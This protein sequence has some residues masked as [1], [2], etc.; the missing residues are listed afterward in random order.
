[1]EITVSTRKVWFSPS[2]GRHF[3]TSRAA[4]RAEA[5]AK[6]IDRYPPE[7]PDYENGFLIYPGYHIKHDEPERYQ[8]ILRRLMRL[9][10]KQT[11]K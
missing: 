7:R 5:H 4:I 8:K 9:I 11:E 2:R 6:I 3:L 10:D 1:M